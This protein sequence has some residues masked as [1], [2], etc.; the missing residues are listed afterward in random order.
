MDAL[1]SWANTN[2]FNLAQ[3]LGIM[4]SL[5]MTAAAAH[6]DAKSREI[7]NLL[8]L[9]GQHREL[10]SGVLEKPELKRVFQDDANVLEKPVTVAEKEFLNLVFVHYQT[11]WTV[12]KSGALMTLTEMKTDIRDFFA[13]PLPRAVW[14]KTKK[15]RDRRFVQ[16]VERA[17]KK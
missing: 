2:W 1:S 13:L 15:M 6:R 5:W 10:W 3:T 14:E 12:V 7:E 8:T 11:G 9:N 16:F 17:L 4:G